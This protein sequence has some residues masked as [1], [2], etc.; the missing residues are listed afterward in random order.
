MFTLSG[1]VTESAPTATTG[2]SGATV[3][4]VDGPNAGR[5]I[6]T[7]AQGNY[8]LATLQASGFTA[9]ASASG[10]QSQARG[11][12]L[13]S[14]MSVTFQLRPNPQTITE[15]LTGQV[16]G[17]S[18]TCSDGTFTKPCRVHMFNI[19]NDGALDA[20][21]TWTGTAD[22]DLSL[23]RSG[24][25]TPIAR[26]TGVSGTE[27]VSAVLAGGSVYELRVTYYD[28]AT[29]ANYMLRVGRMN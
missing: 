16:S 26:S 18:P 10:Y 5:S 29:I 2:I 23:F 3:R 8:S 9:E 20:T 22:L 19:H 21:L 13:T 1:R 11:V 27:H 25:S 14:N 28:G 24:S 12:T 7:D 6:T 4:I 15:T 17:G